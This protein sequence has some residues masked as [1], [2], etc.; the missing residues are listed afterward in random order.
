M[1]SSEYHIS[2]TCDTQRKEIG[3]AV[4][5][6]NNKTIYDVFHD[7]K[8]IIEE[9]TNLRFK[10]ERLEKKKA[11]R[12]IAIKKW[13]VTNQEEWEECFKWFCDNILIIKKEFLT[14]FIINNK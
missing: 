8:D 9:K 2:L 11:S 5:I 4:Y 12:I 13:D 1:G 7:N 6:G 10:W 14:K 3:I